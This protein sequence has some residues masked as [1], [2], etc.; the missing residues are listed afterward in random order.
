MAGLDTGHD[1][2]AARESGVGVAPA[3]P[4][5]AA[6]GKPRS[7]YL[8]VE[9][10]FDTTVASV[11]RKEVISLLGDSEDVTGAASLVC[12]ELVTNAYR[13]GSPPILLTVQVDPDEEGPAVE[14][15]VADGGTARPPGPDKDPDPPGESGRGHLIVAALTA[16]SSLDVG[17]TSTQAWCRLPITAHHVTSASPA[18]CPSKESRYDS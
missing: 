8:S 6:P 3:A 12:S 13:H 10:P 11:A 18:P 5:V 4:Y 2:A 16:G 1:V 17:R 15:T 9:L 7:G 14:I